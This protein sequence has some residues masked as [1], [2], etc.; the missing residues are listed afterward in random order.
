MQPPPFGLNCLGVPRLLTPGGQEVRVKV[1]KHLAVLIVLAV[2]GGKIRRERLVSLLWPTARPDR[3]RGSVATAIS[4]LRAKLGGDAIEPARDWVQLRRG[5]VSLDLDRL[6]AGEIVGDDF[7]P[8][9]E[10]DA[11]LA[12]FE[13]DQVPEFDEWRERQHARLLPA[14][15]KGL[16][17]LADHAR[18]SGD[19]SGLGHY[20]SRLLLLNDLSEAGIK[21]RMEAYALSGDRITAIRAYD[22]WAARLRSEVKATP[23]RAMEDLSNRLRHRGW[24]RPASDAGVATVHTEQWRNQHFVGRSPEYRRLYELWEQN[25]RG[26]TRHVLIKGDSGVGKTTL[27][28]RFATA[29]ALEGTSAA[30]VRCFELESSIPYAT[31]GALL[32]SLLERPGAA[33]TGPESLSE[34]AKIL[35]EIR[36]RFPALPPAAESV[37]DQA[38]LRFADAAHEFL[39]AVAEEHPVLLVIDDFDR[40]DEVSLGILHLLVRR[41]RHAPIM[42]VLTT[43]TGASGSRYEYQRLR[44]GIEDLG[45]DVLNVEP[46]NHSEGE[47]LFEA[48]V[49]EL[50]LRP[51]ASERRTLVRAAAGFPLAM[52]LMLRDWQVH[53][54]RSTAFAVQAITSE[55]LA[56]PEAR[57]QQLTESLLADLND[58]ERVVVH[59]AA[60]LDRRVGDLE[61][62][63]VAGL[64]QA[65]TLAT[66]S[67]MLER[68]ALRDTPAGL[69]WINPAVRAHAYLAIPASMRVSLHDGIFAKLVSQREAGSKIP[70]L[71]LAWHAMRAGRA[72]EGSGYLLSGAREAILAGAARDA[73][74]ALTS[75]M[76]GVEESVRNQA[77]LCLAQIFLELGRPDE[78]VDLV[79][80]LVGTTDAD[81]TKALLLQLKGLVEVQDGRPTPEESERTSSLLYAVAATSSDPAVRAQAVS[82]WMGLDCEPTENS[83]RLVGLGLRNPSSRPASC[84]SSRPSCGACETLL[85]ITGP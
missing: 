76:D 52:E 67:R 68:R 55:L 84:R 63:Q 50:G 57:Y 36:R 64:Q 7:T 60:V 48:L 38:R 23:T 16:V 82:I 54:T 9:L 32:E 28:D 72:R 17:T 79:R 41:M 66:L 58:S 46:L 49:N 5:H 25:K 83:S 12:G 4:F 2:D 56:H 3:A 51:S 1:K 13:I 42:L 73:E 69:E 78:A 10:V 24:E 75:G 47:M 26:E 85:P 39:C 77:T 44:A 11:F 43:R 14:V 8:P 74:I 45:I 40:S 70:G 53:G 35:P 33:A 34:L 27:A 61:L 20:A 29:V 59:V 31:I 18:R 30:R 81:G 21:A 71:E 65:T 15:E 37:G 19:L 80:P 62:Y 6:T 22:E